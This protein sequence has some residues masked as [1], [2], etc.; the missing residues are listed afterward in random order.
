MMMTS[1]T[2]DHNDETSK[3][4]RTTVLADDPMPEDIEAFRRELLRRM[5][6]IHGEWRSC[7]QPICRRARKCVA[8]NLACSAK[9]STMTERQATRAKFMLKRALDKRLAECPEED[10]GEIK[11]PAEREEKTSGRARSHHAPNVR[12]KS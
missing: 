11:L 5:N 7:D 8:E 3:T 6:N 1:N 12:P 9:P 10:N 2:S 4:R